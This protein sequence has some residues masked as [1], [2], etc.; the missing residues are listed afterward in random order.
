[1]TD[2]SINLQSTEIPAPGALVAI[3]GGLFIVALLMAAAGG[4]EADT[5][6]PNWHG[7]VMQSP[8]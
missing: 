8:R 5:T 2:A 1:M 4:I 7:N 6:Q 3:I